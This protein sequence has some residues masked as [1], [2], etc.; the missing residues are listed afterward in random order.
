MVQDLH[1]YADS[2]R[3]DPSNALP[4]GAHPA[5]LL[6]DL[7]VNPDDATRKLHCA[8]IEQ[9]YSD[10]ANAIGKPYLF[11][12]ANVASWP[13]ILDLK[14]HLEGQNCSAKFNRFLQV[15]TLLPIKLGYGP[16]YGR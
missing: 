15:S 14:K 8:Q 1:A 3:A 13:W 5:S 4:E 11:K 7:F 9:W 10:Y 6:L 16:E 12:T 2:F